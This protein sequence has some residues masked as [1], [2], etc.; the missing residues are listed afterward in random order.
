MLYLSEYRHEELEDCKRHSTTIKLFLFNKRCQKI[1]NGNSIRYSRNGDIFMEEMF[2]H[3]NCTGN[4]L[5]FRRG[6]NN[7]CIDG[8]LGKVNKYMNKL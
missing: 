2:D 8:I 5:E 4:V 3:E 6:L 1:E 7:E